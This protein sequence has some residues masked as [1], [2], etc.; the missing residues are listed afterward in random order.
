MRSGRV[1]TGVDSKGICYFENT[2][3]DYGRVIEQ[4]DAIAGSVKSVFVYDDDIRITTD[5]NGKQSIREYDCNGLL[6]VI[7]MKMV[8]A[9]S[10][11]TTNIS[12]SLKKP[13]PK[14]N[15][16]SGSITVSISLP[17]SQTVMGIR[18]VTHMMRK[19]M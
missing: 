15:R 14:A 6:F 5:R 11:S 1:K 7:R 17:K 18:P 9:R 8:I 2:Y 12:T 4:K 13:M 10:M 19:E 16:L 3:D